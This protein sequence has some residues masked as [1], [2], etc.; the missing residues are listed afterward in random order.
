MSDIK[1]PRINSRWVHKKTGRGFYVDNVV[2]LHKTSRPPTVILD[3]NEH[4]Y[5]ETLEVFYQDYKE[6]L[7]G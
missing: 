5:T 4:C 3:R 1:V 6:V 2:N 7:N